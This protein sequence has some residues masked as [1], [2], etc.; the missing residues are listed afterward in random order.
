MEGIVNWECKACILI[1]ENVS[2]KIK[3]KLYITSLNSHFRHQKFQYKM[4]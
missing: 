4:L 1:M 3:V 2:S